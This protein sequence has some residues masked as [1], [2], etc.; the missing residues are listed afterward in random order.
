MRYVY[1]YIRVSTLKQGEHG[2]SLTEQRFAIENYAKRHNLTITE[3]FEEKETAAKRGRTI[4]THML[5]LLIKGRAHGV[6]IHKIDRGARNLRDWAD[7]GGLI[8]KGIEVH[9]AHESLDMQSRGGRLAADIQAVVAADFIRNLR[10]EVKKGF[11]G[12]L[13]QGL[14]PLPAPLGYK[15]QGR[16]LPK[17]PDPL[18]APLVQQAFRL[19]ASTQYNL[20]TLGKE[21]HQAGLRNRRG[22]VVSRNGLSTMLNNEFYIGIIHIVRT[23]ERHQG[24]HEPLIKKSQFDRVQDVLHGRTKNTGLKHDFRYRKSLRCVHCKYN[25]IPERQKGNVYYRCHTRDCPRACVREDSIDEQMKQVLDSLWMP[26]EEIIVIERE[27]SHLK[28]E[29]FKRSKELLNAAELNV[30]NIDARISRLTDA[31]IDRMIDKATFEEKNQKLLHEIVNARESLNTI[32]K[33]FEE[34]DGRIQIFLELIKAIS[35]N[36]D[37]ANELENRDLLKSVTSSFQVDGKNLVVNWKIPFEAVASRTKSPY[38]EPYR[39][40]PRTRH[41]KPKHFSKQLFHLLHEQK[42]PDE[43]KKFIL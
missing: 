17:I 36:R 33:E 39:Y 34:K 13:R 18:M 6:I 28:E 8:D 12:R 5:A 40:R 38:S 10:D 2:S 7:L 23:G 31:Y 14:Y 3:W 21:M 43:P 37:Y 22:G 29:R 19:Y 20:Y 27:L 32:C 15:D 16:G 24:I 41:P 30:S 26:N 42:P 4:F 35:T 11:Q 9:F 1:A 25:L